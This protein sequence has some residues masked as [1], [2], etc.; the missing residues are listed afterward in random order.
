LASK[1][2]EEEKQ[3][4]KLILLIIHDVWWSESSQHWCFFLSQASEDKVCSS[5]PGFQNE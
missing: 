5:L 3:Q 4:D 1:E 2:I